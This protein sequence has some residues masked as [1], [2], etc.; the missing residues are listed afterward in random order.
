VLNEEPA[1]ETAKVDV[2][3]KKRME[4]W[5]LADSIVLSTARNREGKVVTDDPHFRG[6]PE[7]YLI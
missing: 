3:M 2:A 4:G 7:V 1:V 5:G 6:S